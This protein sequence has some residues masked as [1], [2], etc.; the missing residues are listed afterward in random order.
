MGKGCVNSNA[1]LKLLPA[2]FWTNPIFGDSG[3]EPDFRILWEA[4]EGSGARTIE[5]GNG[6]DKGELIRRSRFR[7]RYSRIHVALR[8]GSR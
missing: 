4:C 7:L 5:R 6:N 2:P 3:C 1:I 8:A